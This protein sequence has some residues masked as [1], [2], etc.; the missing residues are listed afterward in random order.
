MRPMREVGPILKGSKLASSMIVS[1]VSPEK[2]VG[3][4]RE[5]KMKK[6]GKKR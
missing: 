2:R 1:I 3:L 5:E 4:R 6:G